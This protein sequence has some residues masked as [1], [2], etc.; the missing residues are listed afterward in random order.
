MKRV[1]KIA[2]LPFLLGLLLLG[3]LFSAWLHTY[4]RLTHETLIAELSFDRV[5][6]QVYRASV[7]TGDL[8]RV[9]LYQLYGDQ[10]RIEAQFIK[11]KYW[12]NLLGLDGMYRLDRIEGRYRDVGEQNTRPTLAYALPR[13]TAIDMLDVAEALGRM[14]F[15]LDA[16][17]GSST[18]H[19]IDTDTVYR[20]YKT[21]T[22]LMTRIVPR[23][24]AP[25]PGSLRIEIDRACGE[26][27]GW[28]SAA[29]RWVDDRLRGYR[30]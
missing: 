4:Q 30:R 28:W 5:G 25:P 11:W 27:A 22:G 21:Q 20:V 15:L 8:C 2:L 7:A 9:E 12:A 17:Y 19:H 16:S 13:E 24:P 6:E 29:S 18:F 14:N 1:F 10:W 3:M 26:Q 23:P